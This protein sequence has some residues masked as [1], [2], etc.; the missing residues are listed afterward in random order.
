MIKKTDKNKQR[1]QEK[2]WAGFTANMIRHRWL[3]LLV[4]IGVSLFFGMQ[5][6]KVHFDN[7]NDIWFVEDHPVLKAKARF[8]DAFGN[9][10]YVY[11]LF[12]RKKRLLPR[13]IF[14]P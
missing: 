2:L 6:K 3:W 9:V 11:I 13:S 7:S 8:D 12:T 14:Q 1:A 5:M 10:D 4:V